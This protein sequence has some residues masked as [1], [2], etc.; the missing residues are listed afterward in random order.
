MKNT[1]CRFHLRGHPEAG[2]SSRNRRRSPSKESDHGTW[3]CACNVAH[4]LLYSGSQFTFLSPVGGG[5]YGSFVKDVLTAHGFP[6]GLSPEKKMAAVTASWRLPGADVL[7]LTEVEYT[8][9]KE[10]MEPC[11]E[12]YAMAYLCGLEVEEPRGRLVEY[13]EKERG[14]QLFCPA[15]VESDFPE[16]S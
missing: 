15:H 5:I 8:F 7:S 10:W 16:T 9:Q 1:G 4:V 6:S 12:D 14:P 11:M 2:S 13:F 3:G